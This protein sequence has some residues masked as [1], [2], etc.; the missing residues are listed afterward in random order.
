MAKGASVPAPSAEERAL[1][2]SQADL[3]NTQKQILQSQQAQQKVLLPFFAEQE[4]YNVE[5]DDAGNIKSISKT[6]N[7]TET[8]RNTLDKEL[9]ERS[10]KALRGELPVDPNLE[11]SLKTQEETLKDRLT[12]QFGP[13]YE[14]SSAGIESLRNQSESAENL[15]A[16]ARRGEL[17]LSEQLGIAREQQNDFTRQSSQDFLRQISSGDQLTTA[18]AFGQVASGYGAAQAPYIQNR[19]MQFQANQSARSGMY[20]LLGSLV[21]AA[22]SIASSPA[23]GAAIFSDE[24]LKSDAVPIS[25]HM[26]LGI[27][28][29]VYTIDGQRRIG[30]FASDVERK[31]PMA[32]GK[33]MGYK[34]VDYRA[35]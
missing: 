33:R 10:L 31:L 26:R 16:N 28:I 8:L 30:V 5:L 18:G 12:K 2:Q 9:A 1:Q 32:V 23:G 3:L 29:Y 20:G 14:T 6:P 25:K 35:I 4:G 21:G 13:G 27:P 11:K 34:T 7:E 24:R 19:Q 15:R 17:T 22:G